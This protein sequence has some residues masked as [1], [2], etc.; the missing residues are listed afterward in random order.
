MNLP[1]TNHPG[2]VI[3]PCWQWSIGRGKT[4]LVLRYP[5][6]GLLGHVRSRLRQGLLQ[7]GPPIEVVWWPWDVWLVGGQWER[8]S[9]LPCW[10]GSSSLCS[11]LK[12]TREVGA[13]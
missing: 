4:L 1:D 9:L 10:G 11:Q 3:V 6:C 5:E 12:G 7:F 8:A 2:H 13:V